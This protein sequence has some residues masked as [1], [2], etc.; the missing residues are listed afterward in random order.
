MWSALAQLGP[1]RGGAGECPFDSFRRDPACV[2]GIVDPIPTVTNAASLPV[3]LL[4]PDGLEHQPIFSHRQQRRSPVTA[5]NRYRGREQTL[6]VSISKH[7]VGNHATKRTPSWLELCAVVGFP[8]ADYG[9]SRDTLFDEKLV[10]QMLVPS[11]TMPHG[12]IAPGG[13]AKLVP[14]PRRPRQP[15]PPPTDHDAR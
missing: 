10:V 8:D 11:D 2:V 6:S 3:Y 14:T 1:D 9:A 7:A 5:M 13:S 15:C 12:A 4:V